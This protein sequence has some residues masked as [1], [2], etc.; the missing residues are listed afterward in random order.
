MKIH[1][2]GRRIAA[3]CV[4]LSL[5]WAAMAAAHQVA[6]V[7]PGA[8]PVQKSF[9]SMQELRYQHMVRQ[10]TDFSCGGAALATILRYAYGREITERQV[11]EGMMNVAN[12]ELVREQGFSMLDMKGYIETQGLRGRGYSVQA[13]TLEKV[14]IPVVVLLDIRG[15]KHFVVLKKTVGER[16]YIGDPA[17][18]NR[19]M[20]KA[21]F[22]AGWNGIVLAIIGKGFDRNTVLINTPEPLTLRQRSGLVNS[23]GIPQLLEFGFTRADLF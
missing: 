14:Q 9:L 2:V 23:V 5:S 18:G 10:E 8:G 1:A 17:L 7:V 11:I 6:G 12:Q 3:A 16:V 22:V 19:V 13:H 20:D 4:L 15:Y 21:D